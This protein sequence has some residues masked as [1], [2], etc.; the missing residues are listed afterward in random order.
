M[1]QR[2]CRKPPGRLAEPCSASEGA[3]ISFDCQYQ[4]LLH[5]MRCVFAAKNFSSAHFYYTMP[6]CLYQM[7]VVTIVAGLILPE[8][9]AQAH[10]WDSP[11]L[12]RMPTGQRMLL[13]DPSW[14]R[15]DTSTGLQCAGLPAGPCCRC[16]YL[17]ARSGRPVT[18][19]TPTRPPAAIQV[20]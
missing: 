17:K 8:A 6:L 18:H 9:F 15:G 14:A 20:F 13:R 2:L 1:G 10:A 4:W 7:V 16:R 19:H 12:V 11:V 3:C 5:V